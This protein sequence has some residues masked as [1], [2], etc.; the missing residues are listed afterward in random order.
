MNRYKPFLAAFFVASC[1]TDAGEA[2]P[3]VASYGD[4]AQNESMR[5]WADALDARIDDDWAGEEH[6]GFDFWIG[7]WGMHWRGQSAGELNHQAEG[8]WTH[9]RVFPI[10]GGKAIVELA[11]A[12]DN[13][14]D[15]SQRGFSIRYLDTAKD[16]WVMAQNWPNQNNNGS[17]FLDQLIGG[18]YHGRMTFYSSQQ[19]PDAD[20][21]LQ[22]EHRRYNFADIRPGE[23]FRWDGSNTRD[24]GATWYTWYIVDAHRQRDLDPFRAA[25]TIFPGVHNKSICTAEPHGAYNILGGSWV[26]TATRADG[27]VWDA[28]FDA[29]L[30]LDG[31][32][33]AGVIDANSVKT[34]VTFG[35]ADRLKRWI[36]YRLDDQ[37]GTPHAYYVSPEPGEG[38]VFAEVEN[39]VIKDEFTLFATQENLV[40]ENALRRTVWKTI[41]DDEL[42]FHDEMRASSDGEWETITTY[43]LERR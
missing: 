24:K 29:G 21:E 10:L 3:R 2:E 5:S 15:P 13:P 9:Q 16:R 19:R 8:S 39:L 18:E 32:A 17:A 11:W 20:G 37:P 30:L 22:L 35:Y 40:I 4:S 6:R 14:E 31:C 26:G 34:F 36:N 23:S 38:A 33:V 43:D 41:S 27:S 28:K 42:V 7:E 1:A 12:R 25:G